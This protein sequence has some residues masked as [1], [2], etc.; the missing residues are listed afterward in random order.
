MYFAGPILAAYLV[1]SMAMTSGGIL[2]GMMSTED[3]WSIIGENP[4]TTADCQLEKM[5]KPN[6]PNLPAM[7]ITIITT[8]FLTTALV[9]NLKLR[10]LLGST[11]E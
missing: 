7:V 9:P 1:G 6:T 4:V 3:H 5:L 8:I 10:H 11:F 2:Q